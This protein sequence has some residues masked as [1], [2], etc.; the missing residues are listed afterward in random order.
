MGGT[1]AL[2]QA[3]CLIYWQFIYVEEPRD[4]Y[5]QLELDIQENNWID[6]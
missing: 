2:N 1:P 5:N 4:S 6:I 3:I